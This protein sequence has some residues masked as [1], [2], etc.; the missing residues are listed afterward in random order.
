MRPDGAVMPE[1]RAAMERGV[2]LDVANGRWNL[3][4]EVARKAM[5]QGVLPTTLSS[6]VT[7]P[8]L[9]GPAYGLTVTMSRFLELGLRLEQVIEMTTINPARA[10]GIDERK[11]SLRPGMDADITIL[12]LLSGTWELNDAQGNALK[13]NALVEPRMSI[14]LGQPITAEPAARPQPID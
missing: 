7:V 12:E 1:L 6:D 3:N 14:K 4:Y 8:S 10:I 11:G 13:V 9:A 2:V 5:A